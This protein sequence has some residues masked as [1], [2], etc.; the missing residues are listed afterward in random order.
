[1]PSYL[2]HIVGVGMCRVCEILQGLSQW[3]NEVDGTREMVGEMGGDHLQCL[4]WSFLPIFQQFPAG[5]PSFF[6]DC[7]NV[8][9]TLNQERSKPQ[10]SLFK[11]RNF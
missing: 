3:L 7:F 2:P 4:L 6:Q 9:L 8:K 5:D 10:P 1:M 11:G